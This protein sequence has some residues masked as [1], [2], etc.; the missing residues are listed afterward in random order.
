[1]DL[2]DIVR[3]DKIITIV[4]G[5]SDKHMLPLAEALHR[6]GITMLEITF[7][8]REPESWQDTA[9]AIGRVAKAM[10]GSMYIGAGTVMS[11]EQLARAKDAGAL[12]MVSP[13]VNEAVIAQAKRE[14]MHAFPGAMTPTEAVRAYAAGANGVK[15]FP[16]GSLGPGYLRAIKAPL[17]H[18]PFLAVG[19]INEQNAADFLRAGAIGVGVGGNIVNKD[20]IEA[21]AWGKITALARAYVQAVQDA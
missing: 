9:Y 21:G 12:Y 10:S 19:G 8:Q 1:M 3:R 6:G 16:A 13:D 2:M 4:R 17:S 15:L 14:G 7:D 11:L 20:W 18:I 5:L